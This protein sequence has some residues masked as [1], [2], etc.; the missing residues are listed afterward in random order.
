MVVNIPTIGLGMIVK[1]EAV[2]LP[3]CLQSFLPS[4]NVV[5]LVDTGS[6]DRTIEIAK[7]I[8]EASKCRHEIVECRDFNDEAGQLTD[9]SA[10]RNQYVSRLEK[11]DVDYLM[12]CDADDTLVTPDVASALAKEPAD[13]YGIKYRMND[14]MWFNSYKIW[15]RHLKV[16]YDGRVHEVLHI[17]WTKVVKD[18]QSV[19]FLHHWSVVEGQ[20]N[21][22]QRNLRI[23][24]GEIYPP[25]R[26]LFYFA[27]ENVDAVNYVEAVK[28]YLE[29]IRRVKSGEDT[30]PVELAHCYFRAA[31]WCQHLGDTDTAVM[32]SKELLAKDPSWS[33]SWCE[34]AYI[35]RLR[36][37]V[38][39][40][41]EYCLKALNNQFKPRLFSEHDKYTTTPATMLQVARLME[42]EPPSVG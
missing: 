32:L 8:L 22:T 17:D 30:W 20:E 5:V 41:K 39:A 25:L 35:A 36:G 3:L 7:T 27:N 14:N 29:Y 38:K 19:E 26:S 33:E 40:M 34:L 4:V 31:R 12:S 10:A 23:L 1:N 24:R 9:F 13:F 2:D 42:K 11:Y 18:I 15:R 6:T 37:D 28:W 21:S 16:R